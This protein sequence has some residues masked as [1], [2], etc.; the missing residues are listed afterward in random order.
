MRI[1]TF[2]LESID[3][4]HDW[5]S[6]MVSHKTIMQYLHRKKAKAE[7]ELEESRKKLESLERKLG[8]RK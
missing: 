7:A 2:I 5:V 6:S 4:F 3:R 1:G 8:R